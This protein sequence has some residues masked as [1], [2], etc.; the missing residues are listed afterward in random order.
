MVLKGLGFEQSDFTRLMPEFSNGWQMRVEL[1]KILL[2]K[3][4]LLLLDEP[5][6]HLDIESIQWLE[7]FLSSYYGAVMLVSHDRAFLD[8][9]TSRTIEISLGRVYDYK[10]SYSDYI[11]RRL[12]RVETMSAAYENQQREIKEIERFIER[13]RYKAS[14]AK[15]VQSRVKLLDKMEEIVIDDLDSRAIHFKFPPAPHSGKI[16]LELKNVSKAYN[17]LKVLTHLDLLIV[18]GEKI[19]FVGRNGEGKS[20]L[21]RILA[22]VL[23][24][25]G[26]VKFG[27]QVSV[28]YYAQNQH[29]MLDME[30]TVFQTLDDVA[31]GD[32]RTRIKG[33]LGAFLFSGDAIDKK[34]K[35]LSG[36]EKARLSLARML[37]FPTNLL[38]LDEPTN[39]L[40]MQ[41]K[42]ILKN[43]LLQFDGTLI[44]VSHDRDFLQGLTTKVIE[45]RK[46]RI[47]EYLGD[48]YDFLKERQ[49]VQLQELNQTAAALPKSEQLSE[50]SLTKQK[51]ERKKSIEKEKRKLEKEVERVEQEIEKSEQKIKNMDQLLADPAQYQLDV[52]NQDWYRSYNELKEKSL[53]LM[54]AWEN[55][56]DQL[57]ETTAE[58]DRLMNE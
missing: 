43:A 51:W 20:T 39:H 33:I 38:I 21:A 12:E 55:L 42:D 53:H 6:N 14:K 17:E 32:I 31:T 36:G 27:H 29:D 45:F 5:T 56:H 11:E 30:K 54:S 25:E 10:G 41:S 50:S 4:S 37:L 8:N 19:A 46:P 22:G 35:V 9:V 26:E 48:V 58:L 18:R 15:Q 16:T 52:F 34:V 2:K 3:P 44:I 47:K 1:A 49:L 23:D 57:A 40:D 24:Y 7:Q 13:F 28:G